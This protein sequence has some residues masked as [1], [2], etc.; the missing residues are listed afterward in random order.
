[1]PTYFTGPLA[2]AP[3]CQIAQSNDAPML[4]TARGYLL[5]S[6]C[7]LGLSRPADRLSIIS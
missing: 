1:M 2:R 5:N 3:P 4:G 7:P 6:T